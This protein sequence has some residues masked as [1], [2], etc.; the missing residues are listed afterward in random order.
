LNENEIFTMAKTQRFPGWRP[1]KVIIP[2]EG[3]N[4]IP[5]KIEIIGRFSIPTFSKEDYLNIN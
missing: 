4:W 5:K 3:G 2:K 1:D